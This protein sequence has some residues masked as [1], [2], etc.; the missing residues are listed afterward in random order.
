MHGGRRTILVQEKVSLEVP[1]G[2]DN[3]LLKNRK[4]NPVRGYGQ[5]LSTVGRR[6]DGSRTK[7]CFP[8][9]NL[10]QMQQST[11]SVALNCSCF[12]VQ[13]QE[14]EGVAPQMQAGVHRY[15]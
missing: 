12:Q 5:I 7:S 13:S 14:R 9:G 11:E 8:E 2:K 3:T 6:R 10:T 15:G 4:T 1:E